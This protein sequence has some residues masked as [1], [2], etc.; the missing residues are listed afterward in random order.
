MLHKDCLVRF[1]AVSPTAIPISCFFKPNPWL[2][3]LFLHLLR[4][5]TKCCFFYS[6]CNKNRSINNK[7][8]LVFGKIGNKITKHT[9]YL[10]K[11][12][13]T[14][15]YLLVKC[16]KPGHSKYPAYIKSVNC[17]P[18]CFFHKKQEKKSKFY[19]LTPQI[20]LINKHTFSKPPKMCLSLKCLSSMLRQRKKNGVVRSKKDCKNTN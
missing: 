16:S 19:R 9:V 1:F 3:R 4:F 2:F 20:I 5:Q 8:K 7:L 6:N 18:P 17:S 14:V 10:R 11:P 13:T 12:L 15:T